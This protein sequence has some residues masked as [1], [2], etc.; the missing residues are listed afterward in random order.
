MRFSR[1]YLCGGGRNLFL[2]RHR[3]ESL[4]MLLSGPKLAVRLRISDPGFIELPA[5][6]GALL[7]Q[8][9][10]AVEHLLRSV[11]SLA[12]AIHICLRLCHSFRNSGAL[13][14]TEI[15]FRLRDPA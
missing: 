12:R 11:A 5:C 1:L 4:E 8:L 13:R 14:R 6:Q 15:G 10:A 7:E 9:L 3:L 2:P